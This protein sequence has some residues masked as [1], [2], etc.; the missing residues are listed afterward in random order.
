MATGH[1]APEWV[2]P[3]W[4]APEWVDSRAGL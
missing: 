2:A 1:P 4:V 3:E